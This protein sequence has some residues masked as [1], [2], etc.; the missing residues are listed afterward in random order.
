MIL[1]FIWLKYINIIIII[2]LLKISSFKLSICR[3]K[4]YAKNIQ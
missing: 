1:D 3:E 2:V 4:I